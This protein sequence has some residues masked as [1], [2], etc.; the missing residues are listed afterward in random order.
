MGKAL[1][2][3]VPHIKKL[4]I[5]ITHTHRDEARWRQVRSTALTVHLSSAT[6]GTAP[7]PLPEPTKGEDEEGA[8]DEAGD[9]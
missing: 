1:S 9:G 7:A 2:I 6:A 4:K 5:I 3:A 8:D